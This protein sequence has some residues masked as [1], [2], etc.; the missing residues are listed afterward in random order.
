M[1]IS[2]RCRAR[3]SLVKGYILKHSV[4]TMVIIS[5][6]ISGCTLFNEP[7]FPTGDERTTTVDRSPANAV[8]VVE[9]SPLKPAAASLLT[10]ANSKFSNGNAAGAIADLD[11]ALRI[12]P[13][14][15]SPWLALARL[16]Q[17]QGDLAQSEN[18]ARRSLNLSPRGSTSAL[19]AEAFLSRLQG[20]PR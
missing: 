17:S 5:L 16:R 14:H 9:L 4:S 10:S 19:E 11:R 6:C 8:D 20:I 12:D 2:T 13:D 7:S 18:L 15:P 3:P 1:Q